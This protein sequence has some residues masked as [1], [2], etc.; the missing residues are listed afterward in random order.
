MNL[1]KALAGL[2]PLVAQAPADQKAARASRSQLHA[3]GLIRPTIVPI[4]KSIEN[5]AA[6]KGNQDDA[7]YYMGQLFGVGFTGIERVSRCSE[8]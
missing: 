4:T 3:L 7:H 6:T 2:Q 5:E 8:C 1:A